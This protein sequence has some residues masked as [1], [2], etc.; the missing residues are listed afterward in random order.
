MRPR[1]AGW[2]LTLGA[3]GV[4]YGDIG[5]SP[6]YSVQTVFALDNGL[7]RPDAH[8]VYGVVSLVFWSITLIVSVKYV[9]FVMRADNDG[10]GGVMALAALVRRALQGTRA[11]ARTA[12]MMLALGVAGAALF[13][14]DS[15]ITP[16]IS[17]LSAIEGL[18]VSSP[19]L[20]HL[21]LPLAAAILTALFVVQRFGTAR[22]GGLF[23]PVMLLWFVVI[24]AAGLRE[25]LASPGILGGLSPSY[26]LAFVADRPY[27]A[28]VAM[29][30]VVLAITGAEALYAD[31]GHFGAPPIRRAWFALVFPALTLNYLA[32]GALIL[33]DP[34][35][36][37]NPFF[38]LLPGW[39]Q[40]PM[41]VLATLATVIASQAV[42]SG[43][44]SM[45]RQALRLGFLPHLRI[46]RPSAQH[47][48]QV[49]L[50]AVNWALF[51]AVLLVTFIFGSSARLATAYGVAVTGTF[52]I[53]TTLLLL[54]ARVHWHWPAWRLAAVVVAFGLIELTY[55]TANLTKVAHGGWLTLLIATLA[56]TVMM[57][58]QRGRELVTACRIEMEGP[59]TDFLAQ[60]HR[61]E[62]I[63]VNGVAVFPH[64]N[65]DTT[66]L[67]LRANLAHNHVLHQR[68]VIISGQTA[69]VP[70]IPWPERL[71]IT[72]L[73]AEDDG[74][75]HIAATFGFQDP[76]DF[77]EVL[78]RAAAAD[79]AMLGPEGD[80]DRAS[81]FLSRIT[82]K[83]TTR[84]GLARW[85]K[86]LFIALAHNAASQAEFLGLPNDRTVTLSAE[87][88]V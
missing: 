20:T 62:P 27:T 37:A 78:R 39:A 38:L 79:P 53:T 46:R 74:I 73:G 13:Y 32:Q 59:L 5:T 34:A 1:D 16:S 42:I 2:A 61:D 21:V 31:M 68:I 11:N 7:V 75:V 69:N 51:A 82:L 36:R 87:V 70:H 54:L 63:R 8:D 29:G 81:W 15:V 86:A 52:L 48:G 33:R 64:P 76:T 66:P 24:G 50:P 44:Y 40:L 57:T 85:R 26:A 35:N 60:L 23:G 19:E 56:F 45:T 55:F 65:K 67:A 72:P 80:P 77:P 25:V 47:E 17:V 30:A 71:I 83:R 41:V 10:E 9:I 14:G 18:E 28:F 88:P 84:P 58:W 4:V 6:L 22:V 49:Y 3:L 12:T 43:A